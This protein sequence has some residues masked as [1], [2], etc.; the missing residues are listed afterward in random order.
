MNGSHLHQFLVTFPNVYAFF[1]GIFYIDKI[2]IYLRNHCFIIC[3]TDTNEGPGKH[4]IL[5]IKRKNIVECFDS[6][7]ID[8][9][10]KA[11]LE[12]YCKFKYATEIIYNETQYQP[13]DSISCG[14]FVLYFLMER[15]YNP[16][17]DFEELLSE[18]FS[19]DLKQNEIDVMEFFENL[20]EI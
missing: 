5:F 8:N 6:L 14:K 10:K 1:K 7:G 9:E 17:L 16:D 11:L 18:C 4:W 19:S 15:Y 13:I 12:K 3:N 20:S 2:P